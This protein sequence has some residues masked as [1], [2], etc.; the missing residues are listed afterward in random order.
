[1][2]V[3]PF[4]H[5]AAYY[6]FDPPVSTRQAGNLLEPLVA[7]NNL[8]FFHGAL[9]WD[10]CDAANCQHAPLSLCCEGRDH[11]MYLVSSTNRAR[12]WPSDQSRAIQVVLSTYNYVYMDLL[13]EWT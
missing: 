8:A 10:P 2:S 9:S 11:Q 6:L 5:I 4:A 13:I 1:M 7:V 12:S 3:T